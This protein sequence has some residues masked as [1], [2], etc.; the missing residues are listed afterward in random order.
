MKY[1][2]ALEKK[3]NAAEKDAAAA[4]ASACRAK[5]GLP[6]PAAAPGK[7][8][9]GAGGKPPHVADH[10]SAA[11]AAAQQRSAAGKS[12][13]VAASLRSAD[14][15]IAG[16]A[17]AFLLHP[18]AQQMPRVLH[19]EALGLLRNA[20]PLLM[21]SQVPR[22]DAAVAA[23]GGASSSAVPEAWVQRAKRSPALAKLL[24]LTGLGKVKKAMFDL[25][26]AVS[27]SRQRPMRPNH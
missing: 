4:F 15:Q 1:F 18:D 9:V 17:L 27:D 7:P 19:D 25:A 11:L 24:K 3:A 16:H 10:L 2:T 22:E 23:S 8:K 21:G 12:I 26:A 6:P 5:L 14:A 13:S 20:A